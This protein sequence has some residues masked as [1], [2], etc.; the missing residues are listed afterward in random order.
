MQKRQGQI[1]RTAHQSTKAVEPAFEKEESFI[2][3]VGVNVPG[4]PA[5]VDVKNGRIVR[6]RPIRWDEKYTR[7]ELAPS[8]WQV[9]ARGKTF[10]SSLKSEP[11]YLSWGYKKRIYSPN[12]VRYPLKRVDWDPNGER[13]AQNRGSSKFVRISWDEA[14]V[15]IV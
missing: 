6:I 10:G 15:I 4:E 11:G 2:R 1:R 7:E 14:L 9:E 12:R 13:N 8:M 5:A 3:D